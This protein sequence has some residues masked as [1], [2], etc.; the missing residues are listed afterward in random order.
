[1]IRANDSADPRRYLV[2]CTA[3]RCRSQMAHGFLQHYAGDR[4]QVFSAGT[5]PRG[6]HPLA[7]DVMAERGIDI[8][9][10]TSDLVDHYA[11]QQFHAV[12]TVCDNAKEAC[13]AFPGAQ[14]V[15]HHAFQDPDASGLSS[16]QSLTLFRRVRDEIGD[17]AQRFVREEFDGA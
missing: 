1:M 9:G 10:H 7:I 4:A 12:I 14:R 8:S 17:W 3:N 13:P 16:V 6:V 5:R 15:I 11:G 2:L